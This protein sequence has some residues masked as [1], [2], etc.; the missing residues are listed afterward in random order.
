MTT[1]RAVLSPVAAILAALFGASLVG[2]LSVLS[3]SKATGLAALA[4]GMLESLFSPWF[5]ILAVLFF[6]LF[7]AA[8]RLTSRPL[9][10]LL[11]WTPATIISMFGTVRLL[12]SHLRVDTFQKRVK[13][14][15]QQWTLSGS[16]AT[17]HTQT[18]G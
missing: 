5:W 10:I 9:R 14:P 12:S 16:A 3:T 2:P 18:N 7:F 13:L 8:S 6:A 1:L 17:A 15:G 4:G 11:F